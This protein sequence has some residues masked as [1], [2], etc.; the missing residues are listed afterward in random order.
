MTNLERTVGIFTTD[1]NL[2]ICSWDDWLVQVTGIPPENAIGQALVELFPELE[3][4]NLLGRFHHVLNE[5]VVEVL[6][7]AFH[8]YVI[9]C[10]PISPSAH[11][12]RMQQRAT[13]APLREEGSIVGTI[14]T[15]EDV[16]G[17]LDRERALAKQLTQP[18]EAVRLKAARALSEE[19]TLDTAQPLVDALGDDSWRVRR[20]AVEGL[21]RHAGQDT[22]KEILRTLRDEHHNLSVLN[23]ALQVLSFSGIDV[24]EP[25]IECLN[26]EDEDLRIYAAQALGEQRDPRAIQPLM[27]ALE[28]DNANVKYHAIEALGI[29]SAS[30]AVD[31]LAAIVESNDFYLA[32]PALDALVKIGDSSVAPRLVPLLEDEILRAPA[33]EALGQL[34]DEDVVVPLVSSLNKPGAPARVISISLAALYDRYERLYESGE[35]IADIVRKTI[36]AAGA[37]NMLDALSEVDGYGLRALALVSGWLEGEAVERALTRLLGR[38]TARAEV[39]EAL[40]RHGSRVTELLI[41]QLEADD[42]EVRQAAVAALGRIGD[43]RAVPA[44]VRALTSDRELVICAAGALAKIGD[45]RAFETLLGLIGHPDASV[46]QATVGAINSLGHPAMSRR[47][48]TLLNDPDPRIRESAVKISGYFGYEECI[49][50]LLGRCHDEDESVRRAALEHI[51]YLEDNRVPTVLVESIENG[52]PKVR[53]SAARALAQVES[54]VALPCLLTALNDDDPW[55]RYF[56]ARSIGVHGDQ[57]GLEA[58]ARLAQTDEANHVRIAAMESL[59]QIGGTRAVAV[60]SPL[61]ESEDAELARAALTG[62]GLIGHRSALAPLLAALNSPEPSRRAEA[63]RALGVRGGEGVV[64]AIQWVAAK[65]EVPSVVQAAIETLQRLA[66]SDSIA[67]LT[68]LTADATRRE[69]CVV[70]LAQL[71]KD[72]IDDIGRGLSHP[73]AGVRGAVVDALGRMKHTRASELLGLALDDQEASVRLGAVSGLAHLASRGAERKLV[74]MA[75]TDPDPNVRRAAKRALRK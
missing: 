39:V 29:M 55:V 48:V 35:Y 10:A 67:A 25:L 23:S 4:R 63:L 75:R 74:A 2:A 13:I 51:P 49:D 20:L 33:V 38:A 3:K 1:S 6:A 27:R 14:V 5:G 11:Y 64:E 7:P 62:L 24:L 31:R 12:D 65:D 42:L 73:Q 36:N 47:A 59:G 37:Q 34:G 26:Q 30:E 19:E 69:A 60:L 16:T 53:A 61:A 32:F 52:P 46:R 22:I 21:G 40:V 17:R 41:E 28:D 72:R 58:L 44:L 18:E 66:T 45:R 68:M 8:H 71:G 57:E 50:S 70:A 15:I 9:S 56:A 43:T 54:S